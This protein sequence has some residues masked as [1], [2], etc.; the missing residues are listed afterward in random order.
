M[1]NET[2]VK[3]SPIAFGIGAKQEIQDGE[4]ALLSEGEEIVIKSQE[5]AEFLIFAG[6]ELNEPIERYGPFVM[7][8]WDEIN[9]ANRDYMMGKF[10]K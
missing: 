2:K 7:N 6:P 3:K 4:L 5:G 9:K 1:E 10:G 8:T